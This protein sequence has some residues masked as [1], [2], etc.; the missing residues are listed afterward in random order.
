MARKNTGI[1][2]RSGPGNSPEPN[3]TIVPIMGSCLRSLKPSS[4]GA[5]TLKGPGLQSRSL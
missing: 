1:Q 5:I 2:W 3:A 4:I